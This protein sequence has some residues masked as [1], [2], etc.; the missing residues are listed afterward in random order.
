MFKLSSFFQ[1]I[2][3]DGEFS[4]TQF[5]NTECSGSL[6]F[7]GR[8]QFL[9]QANENTNISCVIVPLSLKDKVDA[10][11]GIAVSEFPEKAFYELHNELYKS[12]DMKPDIEFYRDST[13]VIHPTACVSNKAYIGANVYIGAGVIIEDYVHISD[14]VRIDSGAIIG[15]SGHYYKHYPEGLFRV[16]HAG[17]VWL[18]EG[19][20]ILSGAIVS[21]SLHTDFTR[22]GKDTV[23]SIQAHVGHGCKV[24]KRCTLTGNVQ[25]S[26]FTCIGDDVWVGPSA[27]IGN[28][29]TIGNNVRI[30]IG[31][32]VIKS[33]PD[34]D[35]VSGNFAWNH[36][37]NIRDYSSKVRG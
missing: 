6:C 35:S 5:A 23:I 17:G 28:L 29:L 11:K 27:T 15:A 13:A 9:H 7:V 8:E 3:R 4:Q 2:V 25:V 18:E 34:G 20:Q 1:N 37:K 36:R 21:K 19:V 31:S 24:G 14:Q 12:H 10:S 32:V 16:E 33:I 22:I 26:G 30:E